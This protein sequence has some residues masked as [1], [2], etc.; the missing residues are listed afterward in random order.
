MRVLLPNEA[1]KLKTAQDGMMAMMIPKI[2]TILMGLRGKNPAGMQPARQAFI[3]GAAAL[4]NMRRSIGGAL[5]A[6]KP[7]VLLKFHGKAWSYAW[8]KQEFKKT[9]Y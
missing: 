3:A 8:L 2:K 6:E 5:V 9:T 7:L 4:P 1:H